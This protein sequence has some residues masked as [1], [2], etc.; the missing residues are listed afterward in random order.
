MC[1]EYA[2]RLQ[3]RSFNELGE[4]AAALRRLRDAGGCQSGWRGRFLKAVQKL[5]E[6]EQ[7]KPV[8]G[9]EVARAVS[10]ISQVLCD[11]L[12]KK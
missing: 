11:E 12:L 4:A 7:G 1:P 3:M 5:E 6:A 2:W 9:R 10:V 8:S